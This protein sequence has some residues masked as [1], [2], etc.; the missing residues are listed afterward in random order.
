MSRLRLFFDAESQLAQEA[1]QDHDE[2]LGQRFLDQEKLDLR[3]AHQRLAQDATLR[4][5]LVQLWVDQ[6]P[7]SFARRW[8]GLHRAMSAGFL[9]LGFLL[10][11]LACQAALWSAPGQVINLW[12]ALAILVA[13]PL[14]TT[15]L[16]VGFLLGSR[17]GGGTW[18]GFG[19]SLIQLWSRKGMAKHLPESARHDFFHHSL[20]IEQKLWLRQ[21]QLF[22]CFL[23]FG[24]VLC[25]AVRVWFS[26]LQ[27]GWSTTTE[28]GHEAFLEMVVAFCSAPWGWLLAPEN[29]PAPEVIANTRW[30]PLARQYLAPMIDG[31]VWWPFLFGSL[32]FWGVLPRT[33]L[34]AYS[35]LQLRKALR[36]LTWSH[37]GYQD[38][39][40]RIL[41]LPKASQNDERLAVE[42]VPASASTPGRGLLLWGAW[43]KELAQGLQRA[44]APTARLG[45]SA[46]DYLVAGDALSSDQEALV[47]LQRTT[48]SGLWILV[49]AGESPDK[50]FLHFLA[51]LREKLGSSF[52]LHIW[53]LEFSNGS[54]QTASDRDLEVWS[55][56]L[57]A[58]HD[59]YLH[60]HRE[61]EA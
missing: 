20:P 11:V 25:F 15:L 34:W 51:L 12:R 53:P 16:T 9:V 32:V 59:R 44:D 30:D 48:P 1:Q 47:A 4:Q 43:A 23:Q 19:Q 55:R 27:F 24:M 31:R 38:L 33:L 29:L 22:S 17:L 35:H 7:S 5:R 50:R 39:F 13:L 60:L 40:Q 42:D 21:S 3:Q 54:W 37:R 2:D 18:R 61:A 46:K 36:A 10:G 52:A 26:E 28:Q 6:S 49:E 58:R 56:T 41:P 8:L 57:A 45:L 14:L